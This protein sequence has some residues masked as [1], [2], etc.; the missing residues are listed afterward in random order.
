MTDLEEKS[1]QGVHKNKT[2]RKQLVS[3]VFAVV[4]RGL[5]YKH[6]NSRNPAICL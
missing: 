2:P 5:T 4:R 6:V 3:E 1:T